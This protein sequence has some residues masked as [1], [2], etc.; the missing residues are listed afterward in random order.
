MLTRRRAALQK[1]NDALKTTT[2]TRQPPSKR[3]TI[4]RT[5]AGPSSA[6]RQRHDPCH[7]LGVTVFQGARAMQH[8]LRALRPG[9]DRL[10]RGAVYPTYIADI[11]KAAADNV[12]GYRLHDARDVTHGFAVVKMYD[13][14]PGARTRGVAFVSL[15]CAGHKCRGSGG[16]LLKAVEDH[17]RANG[18]NAMVLQAT[19][20]P[21]TQRFYRAMGYRRGPNACHPQ[22][23]ARLE[24]APEA[25][26]RFKPEYLEALKDEHGRRVFYKLDYGG[27][28]FGNDIAKDGK[29]D[30][31]IMSK[32]LVSSSPLGA[33]PR[34]TAPLGIRLTGP[35][36]F[37]GYA[38][39]PGEAQAAGRN[40]LRKQRAYGMPIWDVP[41]PDDPGYAR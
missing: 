3:P 26:E 24:S 34:A 2:A 36:E 33:Y 6:R 11:V 14:Y 7:Y 37:A 8:F 15:I 40:V 35:F 1:L 31:V 29:G 23:D 18:C 22:Y 4:R 32:C 17:A 13:T 28:R 38:H 41:Y 16:N 5:A 21:D 30:T 19:D 25:P 12:V 9:Y 27:Q 20:T 10:C 39:S